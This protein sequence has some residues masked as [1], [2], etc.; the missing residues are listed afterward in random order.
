MKGLQNFALI[1]LLITTSKLLTALIDDECPICS[2]SKIVKC[3]RVNNT[4]TIINEEKSPDYKCIC[5]YYE[6]NEKKCTR[7]VKLK[8]QL[9]SEVVLD[10][11]KIKSKN[12]SGFIQALYTNECLNVHVGYAIRGHNL[13]HRQWVNKEHCFNLCLTTN[14]NNGDS[15]NCRSF[16]HWHRDCGPT[17]NDDSICASFNENE[18]FPMEPTKHHYKNKKRKQRAAKLDICVLSN[19]TIKSSGEYFAP[20]NAV[21]YYELACNKPMLSEYLPTTKTTTT[22]AKSMP[23]IELT[24]AEVITS[25]TKNIDNSFN[26]QND[27]ILASK[28]C[29]FNP[30]LNDGACMLIDT[31]RFTCLCKDF[32]YGVYCEN[33]NFNK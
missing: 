9:T 24:T 29:K 19:Q 5:K 1:F 32:F 15:F 20:N 2:S 33:S 7:S 23:N 16:E 13:I 31:Q 17:Q 12:Q 21:T 3:M 28:K 14:T 25:I 6:S 11:E 18:E 4:I 27:S 10:I 26:N 22:A 30:C 8:Q